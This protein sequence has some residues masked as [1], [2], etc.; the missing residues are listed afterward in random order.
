[1]PRVDDQCFIATLLAIRRPTRHIRLE[2]EGTNVVKM[3]LEMVMRGGIRFE[4]IRG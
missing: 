4:E 2:A 3:N 1:M